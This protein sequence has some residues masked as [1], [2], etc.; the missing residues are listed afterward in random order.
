MLVKSSCV[1][2]LA[3]VKAF[4]VKSSYDSYEYML[5]FFQRLICM[6]S[7]TPYI[8]VNIMTTSNPFITQWLAQ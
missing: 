8:V 1:P 2:F 6:P 4:V 7:V 3:D 5:Y